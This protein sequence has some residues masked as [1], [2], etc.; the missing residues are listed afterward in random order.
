METLTEDQYGMCVKVKNHLY[1]MDKDRKMI[2]RFSEDGKDKKELYPVEDLKDT[3]LKT[4]GTYLYLYTRKCI[5]KEEDSVISGTVQAIDTEGNPVDTLKDTDAFVGGDDTFLFFQKIEEEYS[6]ES[7]QEESVK[8]MYY[9]KKSDL[10]S[11][12]YSLR[13]EMKPE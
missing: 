6:E 12:D 1:T 8:H 11:G 4:D 9:Y 5:Q 13:K 3:D 2:I 10:G 7:G